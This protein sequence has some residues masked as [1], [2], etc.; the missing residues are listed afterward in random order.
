MPL[1]GKNEAAA[2]EQ[3]PTDTHQKE[4]DRTPGNNERW[5]LLHSD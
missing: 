2:Q 3:N 5:L 4:N 1:S